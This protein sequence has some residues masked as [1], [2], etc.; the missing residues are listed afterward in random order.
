P[1]PRP[2]DGG[3]GRGLCRGGARGRQ[4]ALADRAGACSAQH[5]ADVD[6]AGDVVDGGRD[7]RGGGAVVLRARP[8]AAGAVLG[9]HAQFGATLSRDEPW[10]AV[11]P[12]LAIFLTV[13]SFNLMGDG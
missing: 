13:L 7:H 12:G 6:R 5:L 9:Q 2:S 11:W 1:D 8:A 3:E 4:S 10:M